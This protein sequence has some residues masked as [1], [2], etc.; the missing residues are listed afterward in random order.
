MSVGEVSTAINVNHPE[1]EE[2]FER[3][4]KLYPRKQGKREVRVSPKKEHFALGYDQMARSIERYV[5]FVEEQRASGFNLNYKHGSK[6]FNTGYVD[7]IDENYEEP[8]DLP[9]CHQQPP[10]KGTKSESV[11]VADYLYK[12]WLEYIDGL[13]KQTYSETYLKTEHWK[14]FRRLAYSHYN[15]NCQLCGK[16]K[17]LNLHHK[18]YNTLGR[19]S[20]AD[21]ILL[22]GK[23]HQKQH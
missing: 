13:D 15:N 14:Y 5:R 8:E 12:A 2:L 16:D 17:D 21:V 18:H 7:Y 23:C 11:A 22:C 19:E 6:F 3:L 4:W 20:F 9:P 10:A 1:E